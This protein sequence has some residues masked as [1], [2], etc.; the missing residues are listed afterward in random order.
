MD[1]GGTIRTRRRGTKEVI[2]GRSE[3]EDNEREREMGDK[4][5]REREGGYN[6]Y[7]CDK[8]NDKIEPTSAWCVRFQVDGGLEGAVK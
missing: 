6:D 4:R 1:K 3:R 7:Q 5:G 8:T 2:K